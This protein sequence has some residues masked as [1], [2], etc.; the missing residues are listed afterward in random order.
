MAQ[1]VGLTGQAG[2]MAGRFVWDLRWTKWH[3]MEFFWTLCFFQV[4]IIPSVL[5]HLL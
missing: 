2:A 5:H 4:I 1:A 3:W